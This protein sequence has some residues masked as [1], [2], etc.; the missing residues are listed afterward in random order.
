M[1]SIGGEP[2][3]L[4]NEFE[5]AAGG[6]EGRVGIEIRSQKYSLHLHRGAHSNNVRGKRPPVAGSGKQGGG[7]SNFINGVAR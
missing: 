5:P 2:R 6:G 7:N 3:I 4:K 1:N